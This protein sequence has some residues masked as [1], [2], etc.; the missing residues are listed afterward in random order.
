MS[1]IVMNRIAV[2]AAHATTF[3][4]GF[5]HSFAALRAVPGLRRVTLLRPAAV[6]QPYVSTME[7]DNAASFEA[8]MSS[9]S[10][11]DAHA[12]PAGST[13]ELLGGPNIVER[14]ET[15]AE[16]WRGGGLGLGREDPSGAGHRLKEG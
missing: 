2:D 6:G 11:R 15:V 16:V 13:R 9:P 5:T 3:E 1:Y 12:A 7:W 4:H 8:W 10:F 14:F